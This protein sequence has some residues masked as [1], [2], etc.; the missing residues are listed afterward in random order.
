MNE[1]KRTNSIATQPDTF[2]A[3]LAERK[4]REIR[5]LDDFELILAGGGDA[6]DNWP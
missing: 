3:E 2:E 5:V 6:V 4:A 1:I